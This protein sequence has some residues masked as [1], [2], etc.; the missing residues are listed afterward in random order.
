MQP[1][2]LHR[3]LYAYANPTV[4]TDPSG[5]CVQDIPRCGLED[6]RALASTP[7]EQASVDRIMA[8]QRQSN[9]EAGAADYGMAKSIGNTALGA[10]NFA[11]NV[12]NGSLETLTGGM[13]DLGGRRNIAASVDHLV[14]VAKN[15]PVRVTE[16]LAERS[17]A[18]DRLES[19]GRHLEAIT[20]RSETV[21]DV[22]TTT[23]AVIAPFRSLMR[24]TVVAES[25]TGATLLAERAPTALQ[26]LDVP[27]NAVRLAATDSIA[28]TGSRAIDLGKSYEAGVRGLYGDIAF[29]QRQYTAVVNGKRVNGIADT[30]TSVAGR[31]VAVEA[32]FVNNWGKSIR[33]PNSQNG[34]KPWA[35]REQQAMLNQAA[36]YS[37]GYDGGVIYHT[38]S[39]ELAIYYTRA[40]DNAGITNAR[41]VIT[42]AIKY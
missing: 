26:S 10:V 14:D 6:A 31:D 18:A 12:V 23:A 34:A 30:V 3:Y 11:A 4:Y 41:F 1:P 28:I 33:N 19:E 20:L 9:A 8:I 42:P 32:K 39:P 40:F 2:S 7:A 29:Q 13:I 21:T 38:N 35:V 22:A 37:A 5:R 36:R 24:S 16:H 27:N 15:L 25:R 17:A